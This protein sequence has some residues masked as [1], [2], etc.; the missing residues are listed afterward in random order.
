MPV[1]KCL[2]P[3]KFQWFQPLCKAFKRTIMVRHN[4]KRT[5]MVRLRKIDVDTLD[6]RV[7]GECCLHLLAQA[8]SLVRR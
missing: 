1:A 3:W 8:A 2:K 5:I 7:A 6:V 4:T